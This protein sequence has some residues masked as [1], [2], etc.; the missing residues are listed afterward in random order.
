MAA[1]SKRLI[2]LSFHYILKQVDWTLKWLDFYNR[3][4]K[5]KR[6]QLDLEEDDEDEDPDDLDEVDELDD[7]DDLELDI[8]LVHF[9]HSY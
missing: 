4:R 2:T 5:A 3:Q 8:E 1:S 7:L 6:Y 9:F